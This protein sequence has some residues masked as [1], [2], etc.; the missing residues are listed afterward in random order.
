M[1]RALLILI[2]VI[3]CGS[4]HAHTVPV[5]V[6]E[7]EFNANRQ[8]VI[9]VNLDPRLF[10]SAQPTLL[11]PVPASWWF[12][13][14]VTAQESTRKA[15]AEYVQRTFAFTVGTAGVPAEWKVEPIDSASAFP[16]GEA[17]TETHLLVEHRG[18]LP[19]S[20][21]DF[22]VAVG[23]ECAVAVILLCSN[24]GDQERRPQSL[25]PGE[26]SRPFVLPA[27]PQTALKSDS[28]PGQA[29]E[30]WPGPLER[31]GWLVRSVHFIGDHL[32]LAAL[33]G[34]ALSRRIWLGMGLLA[35]FHVVDV[36]ATSAVL[37]AWLPP[38]PAWMTIAYWV[39]LAVAAGQLL[40]FKATDSKAF[41]PL[42]AAGLC[43]GL[44]VP[45]LHLPDS[46]VAIQ[47]VISQ[48]G[49]AAL[50]EVTVLAVTASL[51]RLALNWTAPRTCA[52]RA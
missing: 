8:A 31:L 14:D 10:L 51:V 36:L 18:P 43:H 11:P 41:L 32:A 7:A 4:L 13:Q 38:A 15:A 24:A 25:F 46:G 23:K 28:T 34:I 1:A 39:I 27:L 52:T 26:T 3:F 22:K 29:Q 5:V 20:A 2:A 48:S 16:L 21:G 42:A 47:W 49:M 44:N 9:K 17:S 33:L 19:T 12:E 37:T 40:I 45:H 35:A 30:T 50:L 6:I